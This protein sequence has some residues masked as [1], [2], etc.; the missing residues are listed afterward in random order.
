MKRSF[1]YSIVLCSA[2]FLLSCEK[3]KSDLIDVSLNS[4]FISSLQLATSSANLD[5][6]TGSAVVHLPD[7][8]YTISDTIVIRVRQVGG[9]YNLRRVNYY[10]YQPESQ[11]WFA[12]GILFI[13]PPAHGKQ[14]YLPSGTME[15]LPGYLADSAGT[16]KAF[17]SFNIQRCD[18]G[19]Y[20]IAVVAENSSSLQSN[21]LSAAL[22]IDRNN[23][24]PH[25]GG[26]SAPDTL[27]RPVSGRVP[28]FFAV[29]ASDPD[30]PTDI[31][32]VFFKSV[33]SS[34]PNFEFQL[35]DDG[36]SGGHG[37]SVAA[38]G[39][40]SLVIPIDSTATLG[41][42]EFRFWA[43]DKSGALSDSISHFITIAP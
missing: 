39:R 35:F 13:V 5:T 38:D 34:S 41:T 6:T 24:P 31:L 28:V 2:L 12:S 18:I 17:F 37:D 29:N 40:Y 7:G 4:P 19:T 3:E 32:K 16:Y 43:R 20:R 30:C 36:K 25:L 23:L 21:T 26:L 22:V 11:N 1:F 14:S 9:L 10:L 33:N 8:S 42:K 15:P 27:H